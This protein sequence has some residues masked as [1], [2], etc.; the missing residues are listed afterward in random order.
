MSDV[1]PGD[2]RT[3]SA[4]CASWASWYNILR[5]GEY[6]EDQFGDDENDPA[7]EAVQDA[8]ATFKTK[9][10]DIETDLVNMYVSYSAHDRDPHFV[11]VAAS[12]LL[13]V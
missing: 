5:L 11:R 10:A 9:I 1:I 8:L 3:R 12:R 4:S 6:D 7:Y 13:P 2:N